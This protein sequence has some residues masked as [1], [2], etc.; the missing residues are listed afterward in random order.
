MKESRF[1][2][3]VIDRLERMGAFV[4]KND[5]QYIQGI[6]DLV[7]F[8]GTKW[9]F[10]EVKRSRTEAFQ[11]NQE[12]YIELLNGMSFASVIY[13]EAEEEVFDEIQ[14]TFRL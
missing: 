10:L 2:R 4:L 7:F 13:P 1:Q 8:F 5:A 3:E 6:P 11:P 9:G 14:Q 12:Y